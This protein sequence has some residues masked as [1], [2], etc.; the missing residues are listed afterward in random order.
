MKK[1]LFLILTASLSFAAKSR[2][3]RFSPGNPL[4]SSY[5]PTNQQSLIL[6][7]LPSQNRNLILIAT[8]NDVMCSLGGVSSVVAPAVGKD[9][10]LIASEPMP[11][12]DSGAIKQ[13]Y[14]KGN[15]TSKTDGWLSVTV[16]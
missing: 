15:G 16:Y 10:F 7:E 3:V 14:C 8:T 4:P 9:V 11:V 13:I 12:K 1:I 6:S 5:D 2:Q